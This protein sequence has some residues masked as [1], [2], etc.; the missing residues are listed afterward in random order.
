MPL[1][2]LRPTDDSLLKS[3]ALHVASYRPR[4]TVW[5]L[6]L[7]ATPPLQPPSRY[8]SRTPPRIQRDI[9][10]LKHK[11][12][13]HYPAAFRVNHIAYSVGFQEGMLVTITVGS[14]L[15]FAPGVMWDKLTDEAIK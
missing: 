4:L 15:A 6:R 5:G 14:Y 1:D 11:A 12:F 2:A 13:L 8:L 10:R 9:G 3:G 7:S